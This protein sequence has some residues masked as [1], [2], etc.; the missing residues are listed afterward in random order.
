MTT[1]LHLPDTSAWIET[2]PPRNSAAPL[3]ERID[4]LFK[5]DLVATTGMVRLELLGGTR[6]EQERQRLWQFLTALHQLKVNEADWDEASRIGSELRR[7]GTTIPSTDLL[8]AAVAMRHGAVV[9]HRDRHF[10]LMAARVPLK[11]ESYVGL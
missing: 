6:S 2:L 10:D 9:V 8:I 4:E 5:A 7:Q 11:V 1:D 3:R